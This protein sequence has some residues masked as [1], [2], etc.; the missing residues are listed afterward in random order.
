[1]TRL[2]SIPNS[3]GS[4]RKAHTAFSPSSSLLCVPFQGPFRKSSSRS[5]SLSHW[6]GQPPMKLEYHIHLTASSLQAQH[7]CGRSGWPTCLFTLL[8]LATHLFSESLSPGS[9]GLIRKQRKG[10]SSQHVS[11]SLWIIVVRAVS[12]GHPVK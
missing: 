4:I 7:S 12:Q 1:V 3:A 6:R 5:R 9:L 11:H 8:F 10:Q 2:L